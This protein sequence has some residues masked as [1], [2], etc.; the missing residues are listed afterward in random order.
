MIIGGFG[1]K[2]INGIIACSVNQNISE[3]PVASEHILCFNISSVAPFM[4]NGNHFI[5]T[6][7]KKIRNIKFSCIVA[8]FT[9]AHILSVYKNIKAACNTEKGNAEISGNF[10]NNKFLGIN[11][12]RAILGKI[13]RIHLELITLIYIIRPF[14]ACILP[15]RRNCNRIHFL[16]I[17][18][19]FLGNFRASGII[20]KLPVAR[21]Y[22][23]S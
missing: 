9:V 5:F 3:N 21:K 15:H 20:L 11:T 19:E 13:R 2:I 1:F 14:I 8:S 17:R 6:I 12:C 16:F 4:H 10:L 23:Y 7:C 22:G 18:I